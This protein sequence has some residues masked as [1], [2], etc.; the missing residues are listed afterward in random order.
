MFKDN[1][2]KLK[3]I[4]I[5]GLPGSG[6]STLAESLTDFIHMETDM[7]W[8]NDYSDFDVKELKAAHAWCQLETKRWLISL[9]S[10]MYTGPKKGVVI[11]NTFTQK[12]EM[13]PYIKIAEEFGIVPQFIT[14]QGNY[15]SVHNVPQDVID[16]MYNRFE[17]WI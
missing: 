9:D 4:L 14:C 16:K 10:H 8:K 6:K 13:D 12:W 11:S 1:H 17:Y 5:R 15:G 2:K 3:M 7:Y